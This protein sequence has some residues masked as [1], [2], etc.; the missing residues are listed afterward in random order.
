MLGREAD[1]DALAMHFL[2]RSQGVATLA[3]AFRDRKFIE[4]EVWQMCV[5][6]K[7]CTESAAHNP[8]NELITGAHV[9]RH[10]GTKPK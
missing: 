2:A 3:S 9:K 6:L 1:A 4:Q 8:G 7:S 10:G 5:W